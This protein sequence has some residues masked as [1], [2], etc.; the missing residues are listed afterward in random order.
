MN[1]DF[2]IQREF[3]HGFILQASYVG[4]FSRKSLQGDDVAAPTDLADPKSGM[5][6]FTA[7]SLMQQYVRAQQNLSAPNP[8]VVK[9]IFNIDMGVF[10]RFI[11]P[12]SEK[13]SLQIRAEG[14]NITNTP[15][16][17]T[18]TASLSLGSQGSFGKYSSL[19]NTPRVFQFAMRYEF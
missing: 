17:D 1:T 12:F 9:P 14:F 6:Y 11:M 15:N 2:T 18:Y 16:F 7:A 10:K 13:Q 5:D 19:L 8:A 3:S 4:R